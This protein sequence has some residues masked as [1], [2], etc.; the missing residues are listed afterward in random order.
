MIACLLLAAGVT[1]ASFE[2]DFPGASTIKSVGGGR[3]KTA[4]GFAA[5]GMGETAEAAA[6]AFLS[7]YGAAFGIVPRFELAVTGAPAAGQPG[8]VRFERRIDR[9]PVFD[10]DVVVGVD[11][12]N[13]IILVNA[14]DVPSRVTGRARLSR[15][16]ALDRRGD[17]DHLRRAAVR[18][19][20]E[21][22]AAGGDLTRVPCPWSR[23]LG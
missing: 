4:S 9:L 19:V 16:A 7:K 11:A 18:G 22:P 13:T 15:A 10:G 6:R 17:E 12:A 14:A 5:K 21:R 20:P 8:G 2:K 23:E 1:T 3:L